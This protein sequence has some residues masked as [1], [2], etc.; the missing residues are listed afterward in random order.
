MIKLSYALEKKSVI[1]VKGSANRKGELKGVLWIHIITIG[2]FS[3]SIQ[4]RNW[5]FGKES[6]RDDIITLTYSDKP[7]FLRELLSL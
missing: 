6:W 7:P 3:D 1:P 2:L 5:N 4:I